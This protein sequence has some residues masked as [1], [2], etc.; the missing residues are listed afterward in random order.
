MLR[1]QRI[2]RYKYSK[3]LRRRQLWDRDPSHNATRPTWGCQIDD[4]SSTADC[5][6]SSPRAMPSSSG[7]SKSTAEQEFRK[8]FE[9]FKEYVDKDPFGAVFGR[10]LGSQLR[11]AD[12][13]WSSFGW[14]FES[15]TKIEGQKTPQEPTSSTTPHTSR[16][17]VVSASY[18][19]NPTR[20][21]GYSHDDGDKHAKSKFGDSASGIDCAD[22]N[23]VYEFDPISMRKVLKSKPVAEDGFERPRPL[24][25]PLFAE[26]G[27]DIPV[28]PYKPHRVFG[29]PAKFNSDRL[30]TKGIYPDHQGQKS[31]AESSRVAQLRTLRAATLGN[32]LETTAEYYGKWVPQADRAGE[33]STDKSNAATIP[34]DAP[35]FSGTTYE[36]KAKHILSGVQNPRQGWLSREG[37]GTKQASS[38]N[39]INAGDAVQI[40]VGHQHLPSKLQPSLDRLRSEQQVSSAGKLEPSLD[41]LTAPSKKFLPFGLSQTEAVYSTGAPDSTGEDLDLLRASDI[42]ASTK[43]S[44]LSKQERET[45]K[46]DLRQRL[47]KAFKSHQS[48]DEGLAAACPNAITESSKKISEGLNN[49]WHRA[50]AQQKA[51][52]DENVQSLGNEQDAPTEDALQPASGKKQK[53]PLGEVNA[54]V[55]VRKG[56]AKPVQTF[57]PSQEV[58]DAENKSNDRTLALRDA[59]LNSRRLEAE[60]KEK[61]HAL[62]RTIK[63]TYEDSYGLITV[64]HRQ[65]EGLPHHERS[66]KDMDEAKAQREQNQTRNFIIRCENAL[67]DSKT[68]RH[69]VS[70]KAKAIRARLDASKLVSAPQSGG[71]PSEQQSKSP[72]SNIEV[73]IEKPAEKSAVTA[74][75]PPNVSSES[76]LNWG[77]LLF[78]NLAYNSSEPQKNTAETTSSMTVA[79]DLQTQPLDS[80]EVL[81]RL[82][83]TA[84]FM[85]YFADKDDNIYELRSTRGHDL[86]F[87]K[88]KMPATSPDATAKPSNE[89]GKDSLK[90]ALAPIQAGS[91]AEEATSA[92]ET[93]PAEQ[94]ILAEEAN[95]GT[96][97]TQPIVTKASSSKVRRQENVFSG[98]AQTWHQEEADQPSTNSSTK[99][100]KGSEPGWFRRTIKR[101]FLVGTLA[102]AVAYAIGVVAENAGAQVQDT[103]SRRRSGRPGIYSTENSR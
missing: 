17:S 70:Q 68:I 81:S 44:R 62:A 21:L 95:P 45:S 46:Q 33:E 15:T 5:Q 50:R 2:L 63:A 31:K 23:D 67:R 28:K 34:E 84:K 79:G 98:S 14:L 8:D 58:L 96:S 3:A 36:Q 16:P 73:A 94:A 10:R 92:K 69:E 25:D 99:T 56:P 19:R 13:P 18:T 43:T 59:T 72:A 22:Q 26:K 1:K 65:G 32:S 40:E 35:L 100:D 7:S 51:W 52:M 90:Q 93:T 12:A 60:V 11:P 91:P 87:H 89:V 30:D 75:E 48:E 57:T 76:P 80:S 54:H 9:Y 74:E 6:N 71:P 53:A 47:E 49:L 29:Y 82:T 77:P 78:Q 66:G 55:N 85:P 41:R 61:Q 37:F 103:G 101:V 97:I 88:I 24:F 64:D 42:R 38:V 86:I 4:V 39:A 83:N 27:I 20:S 102:G